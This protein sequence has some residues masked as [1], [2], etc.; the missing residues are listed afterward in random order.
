ML[1]ETF[2]EVV[3][4]TIDLSDDEILS[5]KEDRKNNAKQIGILNHEAL[6]KCYKTKIAQSCIKS[7]IV[8]NIKYDALNIQD[9]MYL[10]LNREFSFYNRSKNKIDVLCITEQKRAYIFDYKFCTKGKVEEVLKAGNQH[11]YVRKLRRYAYDCFITDLYIPSIGNIFFY[12]DER[13]KQLICSYVL[14]KTEEELDVLDY[15]RKSVNELSEEYESF[16]P[17]QY[18]REVLD[19]NSLG[20][21]L[22]KKTFSKDKVFQ[23]LKKFYDE[24]I[25]GKTLKFSSEEKIKN[26]IIL[27]IKKYIYENNSDKF[28]KEDHNEFF[29]IIIT[30]FNRPA[31][32][33]RARFNSIVNT[34]NDNRNTEDFAYIDRYEL[35]FTNKYDNIFLKLKQNT[36]DEKQ[37]TESISFYDFLS[38]KLKEN[39]LWKIITIIMYKCKVKT[40][41]NDD[42][43]KLLKSNIITNNIITENDFLE[44]FGNSYI[45]FSNKLSSFMKIKNE[46]ERPIYMMNGKIAIP[47]KLYNYYLYCYSLGIK[48]IEDDLR[49]QIETYCVLKN[50]N[51]FTVLG[52]VKKHIEQNNKLK[53]SQEKMYESVVAEL[54]IVKEEKNVIENK[55][56][57]S[58]E[59]LKNIKIESKEIQNKLSEY[60]KEELLKKNKIELLS[61]M[62]ILKDEELKN[63]NEDINKRDEIIS[64]L[65]DNLT[66][67]TQKVSDYLSVIEKV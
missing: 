62:I 42:L 40:I 48:D 53:I 33:S 56:K 50:P 54:N 24:K 65:K 28:I 7:V 47:E 52:F 11:P 2:K 61:K 6:E 46:L 25:R 29:Y 34:I 20:N 12:L 4:R 22:S 1:R 57:E 38:T 5:W 18:I 19:D 21:G 8:D 60:G 66:L 30:P 23:I 17:I 58:N 41:E 26:E 31:M 43:Y 39:V 27:Q 59:E 3:F 64:C 9:E 37:I 35:Y 14:Y 13:K 16:P 51:K 44:L 63:K 49:N 10:I 45:N 15:Y 32:D 67:I 55:L 36:L